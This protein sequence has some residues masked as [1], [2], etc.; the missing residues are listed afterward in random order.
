MIICAV[1]TKTVTFADLTSASVDV[2]A[3]TIYSADIGAI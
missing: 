3:G 2:M 1:P